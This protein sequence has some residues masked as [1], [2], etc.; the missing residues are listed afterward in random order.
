MARPGLVWG[1]RTPD[2]LKAQVS[3]LPDQLNATVER[4]V[5]QFLK[6]A[7]AE[8]KNSVETRGVKNGVATGGGRIVTR[9]MINSI[10]Y[11]LSYTRA[12]R[13]F[14]QFGYVNNAPK[15]SLFQ[16]YGTQGGQG[17]GRGIK[18]MLAL[19]DAF[20]NFE[21]KMQDAFNGLSITNLQQGQYAR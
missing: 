15:Y 1:G 12:G 14:G 13:V 3:A 8:M 5:S 2:D 21:R 10:D 17:N 6:E 11:V 9:D 16:E 19:T 18:E 20:R 7:V 4:L